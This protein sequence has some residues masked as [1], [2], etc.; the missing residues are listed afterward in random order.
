MSVCASQVDAYRVTGLTPGL[1]TVR[2]YVANLYVG[3]RARC[4]CVRVGA[5]GVCASWN[6][7][8]CACGLCISL[9]CARACACACMH[10]CGCE[11][12]GPP[13]TTCARVGRHLH[14]RQANLR[15]SAAGP[16][17]LLEI[18][19]H[20]H[21]RRPHRCLCLP[22]LTSAPPPAAKPDRLEAAVFHVLDACGAR[23]H[24]FDLSERDGQCKRQPHPL[25][26]RK[27]GES[28]G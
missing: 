13:T 14:G 4:V 22:A 7:W 2:Y 19:R 3:E 8:L 11:Q 28:A 15:H 25:L 16:D 6:V 24:H 21:R 18:R 20:C 9:G 17:R 12:T 27:R 10:A 26:P 23:S 5:C 1:Y